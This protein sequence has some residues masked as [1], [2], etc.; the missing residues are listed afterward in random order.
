MSASGG[1]GRRTLWIG[2]AL[3]IGL[4]LVAGC[5]VR[6][7]GGPERIAVGLGLDDTRPSTSTSTSTTTS[8]IVAQ[9]STSSVEQAT[10]TIV[11][12]EN[13][14]LYFVSGSQLNSTSVPLTSP[15]S[16]GQVMAA[17]QA[18][19]ANLGAP[20]AGLRSALPAT[21][22]IGVVDRGDG[23][24]WVDLPVTFFD[25][26]PQ[27]DQVRAIGQIVLTLTSQRGIGGVR[28]FRGGE[29]TGVILGS[30]EQS[31]PDRA[32]SRADYR[33]LVV[34]QSESTAPTVTTGPV[35]TAPATT[36]AAV[37]T[38]VIGQPTAGPG[39]PT[40]TANG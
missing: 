6:D 9:S 37:T 32:V 35:T 40:S 7:S 21:P 13:V 15:A 23:S 12:T 29:P 31:E 18:G 17:L 28:F 4:A 30:G 19:P 33:S 2:V 36:A 11:Q 5:G 26:I 38:T 34:G 3:G 10:T 1:L 24:A 25:N 22:A 20:G 8:T 16:L 27:A 14:Y 39:P